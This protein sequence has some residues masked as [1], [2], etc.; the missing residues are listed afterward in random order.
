MSQLHDA[1][2]SLAP[3]DYSDV[4]LDN[5]DAYLRDTFAQAELIANSVPPP[6]GGHDFTSSSRSRSNSAAP[7]KAS[8]LTPSSAR[9]P[10]P[11]PPVDELRKS[12]GKPV[13]ISAKENPMEISLYK[14][15]GRDRHGAWF[16][17]SSVHEGLSFPKWKRAMQR[18]FL[19]GMAAKG[20]PGAGAV[21][22]I[23]ADRRLAKREV[24]GVGVMEG[25]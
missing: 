14:M 16:A 19:A 9:L 6:P 20:G 7:A 22:G 24:E 12:W 11:R 13:K 2:K 25:S 18:E 17:R 1:L 10:D 8:D 5:L 3:V 23:A 4:P 21:R 15:A